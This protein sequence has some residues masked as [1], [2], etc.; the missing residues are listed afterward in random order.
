MFLVSISASLSLSLTQLGRKGSRLLCCVRAAC[1]NNTRKG[2]QPPGY[3][4]DYLYARRKAS[5]HFDKLDFFFS[6]FLL[7]PIFFLLLPFLESFFFSPS[8]ITN[9]RDSRFHE[10]FF[11]RSFLFLCMIFVSSAAILPKIL[12][13]PHA[14]SHVSIPHNVC[15]CV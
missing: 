12:I 2:N 11:V 6:N 14:E 4:D 15:V 5:Y 10:F 9:P 1:G 3:F 13:S 8:S 7:R